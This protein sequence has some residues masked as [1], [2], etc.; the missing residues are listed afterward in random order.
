MILFPDKPLPTRIRPLEITGNDRDVATPILIRETWRLVLFAFLPLLAWS[1]LAHLQ[2]VAH[3]PGQVMP[4]GSVHTIQ[5]LEGGIIEEVLVR[6]N[7]IVKANDPIFRLDGTQ[8]NAELEQ[9]DA[10]IAGLN[11]RAIRARAFADDDK[12][13]F[14]EI[15][16]RFRNLVEGQKQ[17]LVDQQLALENSKQVIRAQIAQRESELQSQLAALKTAHDQVTLT[18]N[19]LEIRKTLL[20]KK[21]VSRIVYLETMKANETAMGEVKRINKQIENIRGAI[22]EANNRLKQTDADTRRQASDEITLITNERAQ[23]R[24]QRLEILDR[25]KRLMIRTPVGGIA[26]EVNLTTKVLQPGGV[27]AKIVPVQDKMQ[28]EIHISPKD[29]GRMR[30]GAHVTI[31]LSSY[32]FVYFG[33]V[34]GT[35]TSVSPSTLLDEKKEAYY[36]GIVILEKG[37]LGDD[38]KKNPILPGM[39]A[40][41]DISLDQRRVIELLWEPVFNT[42]HDAF[43]EH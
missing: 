41:V 6:E 21:A 38:P 33:R 9:I 1:F 30:V 11:V 31:K 40:Q 25:V 36:K 29:I 32:S 3:A 4:S 12:A 24:E 14:S 2:E 13:D 20:E 5:H 7:A 8:V 27:V 22:A 10:K 39:L 42:V 28:I 18:A 26:Q 19:M 37:Y 34:Y 35:L 16:D 15:P 23:V 43:K 17:A